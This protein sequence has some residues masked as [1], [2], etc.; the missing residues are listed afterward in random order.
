MNY[1]VEK[2]KK[3]VDNHGLVGGAISDLLIHRT[4]GAAL[5]YAPD[6]RIHGSDIYDFLVKQLEF[7]K[8][9]HSFAFT[10]NVLTINVHQITIPLIQGQTLMLQKSTKILTFNLLISSRK[11]HNR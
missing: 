3:P 11:M 4:S 2:Y 1:P 9:S 6:T 8:R 10:Q 7:L 5:A